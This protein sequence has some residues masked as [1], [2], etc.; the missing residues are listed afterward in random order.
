MPSDIAIDGMFLDYA[1]YFC[2]EEERIETRVAY[3]LTQKKPQG[4]YTWNYNSPIGDPHTTICVIEGFLSYL[5]HG[6]RVQ[7]YLVH[8]AVQEA[9]TFVIDHNLFWDDDRCYKKLTYP[10]Y[11]HYAILRFLVAAFRF[12]YPLT[13]HLK[14]AVQ[15][16]SSKK[17][18]GFWYL[19]HVHPGTVHLVHEQRREKK[20]IHYL[21]TY[22]WIWI[23][24]PF[25]YCLA[26]ILF[27]AILSQSTM[28]GEAIAKPEK[29]TLCI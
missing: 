9:I 24:P 28:K 12:N 15:W 13:E 17:K 25:Q 18:D 8:E 23:G 14:H 2:R 27:H 19:E 21:Q 5:E 4:G 26:C 7:H 11:Y 16:L 6:S 3:L 1:A 20:P 29:E 10:H 22:G